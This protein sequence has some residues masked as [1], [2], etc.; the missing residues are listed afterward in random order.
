M[1][2]RLQLARA[3][4][5]FESGDQQRDRGA[6]DTAAQHGKERRF[7]KRDHAIGRAYDRENKRNRRHHA[8]AGRSARVE[9]HHVEYAIET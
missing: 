6:G 3:Q 8:D 5:V 4:R 1:A 9:L 2:H 7:G